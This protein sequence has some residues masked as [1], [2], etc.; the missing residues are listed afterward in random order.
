VTSFEPGE[1]AWHDRRPRW[2]RGYQD[3]RFRLPTRATH[4]SRSSRPSS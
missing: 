4:V 2:C 1:A 3:V